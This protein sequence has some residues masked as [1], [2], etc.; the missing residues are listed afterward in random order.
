[1]GI[2]GIARYGLGAVFKI[3]NERTIKMVDNPI[4]MALE[5]VDAMGLSKD[6]L[7][8]RKDGT[9]IPIDDSAAPISRSRKR[10]SLG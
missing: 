3:V 9:E 2:A 7:L 6:T 8:I 10:I 4:R 1:M 5:A